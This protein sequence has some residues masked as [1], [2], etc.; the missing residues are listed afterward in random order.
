M[1]GTVA[2]ERMSTRKQWNEGDGGGQK[3]TRKLD[4]A[5]A[6]AAKRTF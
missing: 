2:K 4:R 6:R 1:Q 5:A 3:R